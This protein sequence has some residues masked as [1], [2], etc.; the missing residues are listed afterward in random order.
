MLNKRP[1]NAQPQVLR[2]AVL[3]QVD[4][5]TSI[6]PPSEDNVGDKISLDTDSETSSRW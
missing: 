6:A 2:A 4:L 3:L 5:G 1:F